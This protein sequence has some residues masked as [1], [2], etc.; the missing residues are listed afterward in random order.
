VEAQ[1]ETLLAGVSEDIPVYFR[2]CDISK[3]MQSLKLGKACGLMA[4][5]IN[6]SCI[7]QEDLLCI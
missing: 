1:V 3:E 2:P 4:F 6:V 7:F 5:Q